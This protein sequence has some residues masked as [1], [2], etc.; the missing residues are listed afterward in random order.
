MSSPHATGTG[1]VRRLACSLLLA[2]GGCATAAAPAPPTI[3]ASG[4]TSSSGAC[5]PALAAGEPSEVDG[6]RV[7]A[8]SAWARGGRVVWG[9]RELGFVFGSHVLGLAIEGDALRVLTADGGLFEVRAP[10]APPTLLRDFGRRLSPITRAMPGVV[11]VR[12]GSWYG[13]IVQL[14]GTTLRPVPGL[15][16]A[17]VVDV[18]FYDETRAIVQLVG[19]AAARL[20][21]GRVTPIATDTP[22]ARLTVA[23]DGV[24]GELAPEPGEPWSSSR[25]V[26]L[27]EASLDLDE[28]PP[29]LAP[30]CQRHA[31]GP[32]CALTVCGPELR[33]TCGGRSVPVDPLPA[34]HGGWMYPTSFGDDRRFLL[35]L[36]RL[37]LAALEG[38]RFRFRTLALERRGSREA[39][40]AHGRWIHFASIHHYHAARETDLLLDV[41]TGQAVE[42]GP[43]TG[44][45]R[46]RL[47]ADG[48][49]FVVRFEDGQPRPA[50]GL[51]PGPL[52]DVAPPPGALDLAFLDARRGV[53]IGADGASL[54]FTCDGGS[55]WRE[56][57]LEGGAN[58]R[59]VVSE[60]RGDR[61]P[62][63]LVR[64]QDDA[65]SVA[66]DPPIVVDFDPTRAAARRRPLAPL[67][68]PDLP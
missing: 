60:G 32:T 30:T 62:P 2:L 8:G 55:R 22:L 45:E 52:E 5:D 11:Q 42:L 65:C 19:G 43:F 16:P 14:E 64:C 54:R 68:P 44:R 21:D 12:D 40:S 27:A 24:H 66:L 50:L 26:I 6:P 7:R 28:P 67:R 13:T 9:E 63:G 41:E 46:S 18:A 20:E 3:A 31:L 49:L 15:P 38:G 25:T 17:V 23:T 4:G 35:A 36:D 39:L 34:G 37:Y 51:A 61:T 53:A 59:T 33:A 57:P 1:E 58:A 10:D 48:T 56:L 29:A 47:L